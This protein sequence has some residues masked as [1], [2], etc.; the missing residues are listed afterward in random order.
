M[1]ERV[2]I[3]GGYQSDFAQN[4]HRNELDLLDVFKD[5][6]SKG[7]NSVDLEQKD[8]DVAHVG[9]FTAELFCNQGHLGGFFVSSHPDFFGLPSSRHEAAC[10]SGSIAALA[11]CAEIESGRYELAAVL[12]I[13]QM[14]NV[15]GE[16]AAQNIGGPAMR[17]GFECQDV[18]YPW[19]HMFSELTNEYDKRYSIDENHLS[20]ISEINFANAKKNPNSQTRGWT[21][22]SDAFTRSDHSN[23]VIEGRTRKMDCGQITDGAAIIFLASEKK[24]KEYA[25]AKSI[26]LE[27]IPYIKGWGHQT[28]PITYQEKI[29]FSQNKEYV[30]PHVK[31]AIDDAFARA[32]MQG[33]ADIDGI[34]T[35]DC[36][37]S[38][39]YMAIDHFGITKPGESWKAIESGDIEIRGKIPINA[40]GGLIGLGHPVGATGVRMLLDCYKQCTNNAGDYQI[41]NAKNIS[42][43]NIGGSATTVVSFVVG[44][45]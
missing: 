11:A 43:L 9:N 7:L 13:E 29:D 5:T 6:I 17:S 38:T 34:E 41:D 4:W 27:S 36:F 2:Y 3:L 33:V 8:V 20:K 37:T 32:N 10:A 1:Q 31:K 26:K 24:A 12:G 16:Q 42:T 40:S 39:E 45:A 14:R 15:S 19:P 21:F 22:E 28:G 25:E 23:P 30:F 35:H 44:T 18:Q